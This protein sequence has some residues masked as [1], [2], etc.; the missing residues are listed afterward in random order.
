MQGSSHWTLTINFVVFSR[1]AGDGDGTTSELISARTVRG[2]DIVY[3]EST[4]DD[5]EGIMIAGTGYSWWK[6][7]V[8]VSSREEPDFS[9]LYMSLGELAYEWREMGTLVEVKDG[10]YRVMNE[11]YRG[12]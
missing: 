9:N 4:L 5:Y 7:Q 8:W 12:W 11:L 6:P 1:K 10:K 3:S 2:S